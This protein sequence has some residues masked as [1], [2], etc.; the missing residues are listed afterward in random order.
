MVLIKVWLAQGV[1]AFIP[2]RVN[3]SSDVL[4]MFVFS[5]NKTQMSDDRLSKLKSH[6]AVRPR[7]KDMVF[8]GGVVLAD[9][10]TDRDDYWMSKAE[11]Y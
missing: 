2:D 10:M 11:Q 3:N 8:I 5:R 4:T 7:R 6:N 9:I 1:R